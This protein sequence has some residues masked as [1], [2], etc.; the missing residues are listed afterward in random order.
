M[1]TNIDWIELSKLLP[2]LVAALLAMVVFVFLMLKV[3]DRQ[4]KR[5]DRRDAVFIASIK[6]QRESWQSVL[7]M[8][9]D[10][11]RNAIEGFHGSQMASVSR[12]VD[13][14][15]LLGG[16]ISATNALVIQ[17]DQWERLDVE[18]RRSN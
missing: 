7:A 5:D 4:D 8:K 14:T 10:Q 13:E 3:L 11:W 9:D 18:R 6:E 16:L 12:M 15:K 2:G 1:P 17:H